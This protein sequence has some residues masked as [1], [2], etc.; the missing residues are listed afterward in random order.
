MFMWLGLVTSLVLDFRWHEQL[1][2]Q[3]CSKEKFKLL[4]CSDENVVVLDCFPPTL[5]IFRSCYNTSTTSAEM[6]SKLSLFTDM[7]AEN[8]CFFAFNLC[9]IFCTGTYIVCLVVL[10]LL[11]WPLVTVVASVLTTKQY[12][13]QSSHYSFK[14]IQAEFWFYG[15]RN[16]EF[17]TDGIRNSV[18][19]GISYHGTPR[20]TKFRKIPGEFRN[21]IFRWMDTLVT[22]I[23]HSFY[24]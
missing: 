16:T 10:S 12:T 1:L 23:I 7:L 9:L 5:R 24:Y 11:C 14:N 8:M 22:G 13:V 6:R 21:I 15:V 19:Y 4:I 2:T 20:N 18:N 3:L 17:S